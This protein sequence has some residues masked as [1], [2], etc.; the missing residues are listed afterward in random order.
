LFSFI[1]TFIASF[2]LEYPKIYKYKSLCPHFIHLVILVHI[3]VPSIF[4]RK[5]CK[6]GGKVEK[7]EESR[8]GFVYATRSLWHWPR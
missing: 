4:K 7:V 3:L 5:L 1:L 8:E 2:I 6:C